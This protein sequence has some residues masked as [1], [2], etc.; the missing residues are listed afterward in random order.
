MAL[1]GNRADA[2]ECFQEACASAL[3]LSRSTTPRLRPIARFTATSMPPMP[4]QG[5][6]GNDDAPS[7]RLK[8]I[9]SRCP[10]TTRRLL[11]FFWLEWGAWIPESDGGCMRAGRIPSD[12]Y[13]DAVP[14][15]ILFLLAVIA[16]RT[17][18]GTAVA[19]VGACQVATA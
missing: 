2:D 16:L 3:E 9:L 4:S 11:N 10:G 8:S 14:A 13:S 7:M 19:W 18:S 17:Y 15:A 6:C 1:L 5:I 12:G